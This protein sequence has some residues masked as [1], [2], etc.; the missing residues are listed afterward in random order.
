MDKQPTATTTTHL[1]ASSAP[2]FHHAPAPTQTS[3][4]NSTQI[5]NTTPTATSPPTPTR[6]HSIASTL[7]LS[8]S[9]LHS[10]DTASIHTDLTE[11]PSYYPTGRVPIIGLAA[12][13]AF[14]QPVHLSMVQDW[15][16]SGVDFNVVF[17]GTERMV[18]RLEGKVW[19]LRHRVGTF[20]VPST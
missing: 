14:P 20:N 1:T 13:Y 11:L 18:L 17:A 5:G 10:F 16:R 15:H 9:T 7:S 12:T 19:G 2:K 8:Q 4:T 3:N 6:Q